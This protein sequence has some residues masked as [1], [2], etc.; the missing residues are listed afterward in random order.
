MNLSPEARTTM[1]T[2]FV[3]YFY[4]P[5]ESTGVPGSLRT[6]KFVR[7]LNKVESHVL[8]G[9]PQVDPERDALC[10]LKLPVNGEHIHRVAAWDIFKLLLRF[11]ALFRRTKS[12]EA[13]GHSIPVFRTE[14]SNS[15][16][17]KSRLQNL[18]DFIYDLCYFPDQAGPWILPAVV[19]GANM[20]RRHNIDTLFATGSPWS[21]LIVGYLISRLT[22]RPLV[23]DF[24]DPWVN[25]PFH[26]SKGRFLDTAAQK[27]EAR[28]VRHAAAISLN[29]PPLLDEFVARYPEARDKFF[30]M[31]N[32][33][34]T[35]DFANIT[36]A[37]TKR[38]HSDLVL[39]HAGFLYGV[40]DPA[41]LL[42]AIRRANQLLTGDGVQRRLVFHQ[43]GDV[44]LGYNLGERFG[45]LI[46]SGA[47]KIDASQPYKECL[48]R[49]AAADIV[50]NIQPGTKT[51]VP[52]KLYDYLAIR[53]PILNITPAD[54]AL[55]QLVTTKALG[56]LFGF[57]EEDRLVEAL[58]RIAREPTPD[59]FAG[60]PNAHEFNVATIS[61]TLYE[62]LKAVSAGTRLSRS[63][64]SNP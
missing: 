28:I 39:C 31:P 44:Q 27:L 6:V 13:A 35:A 3:A 11:R 32:G 22:N 48:A 40:R 55:G 57:E 5:T 41:V 10:H 24:R 61:E 16:T 45:D 1:K 58:I 25:N 21:G 2:L 33:Y 49:L 12:K 17:P 4:P 36:P 30:V 23:V 7:S 14:S 64:A 37:Q 59:E 8:T 47:L 54:G 60:Y 56:D 42:N 62:K 34:D 26:H 46:E 43:I 15:S 63:K 51:Q 19:R 9:I 38:D 18:K 53:R 52:S 20:V 29:T 50:V